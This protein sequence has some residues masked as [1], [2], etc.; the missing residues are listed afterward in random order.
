MTIE[1]F[2]VFIAINEDSGKPFKPSNNTIV[3]ET[4][5]KYMPKCIWACKDI[6]TDKDYAVLFPSILHS[7]TK[8]FN[9]VVTGDVFQEQH[10]KAQM[11]LKGDENGIKEVLLVI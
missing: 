7:E 10:V 3:F 1:S 11:I 9:K 2:E 5:L 4:P 8:E 6:E